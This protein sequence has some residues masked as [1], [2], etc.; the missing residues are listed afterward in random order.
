MAKLSKKL[1]LMAAVSAPIMLLAASGYSQDFDGVKIGFLT[2][3]SGG[4]S[5]LGGESTAE[6]VRMAIE[7]F[8]GEVLGEPIELLVGDQLNKPDVGLAIAR[9][10][11]ESDN[12]DVVVDVN[13][14]AVALAVNDIA[15]QENRIFM[16]GASSPD[17]V[18]E[19]CALTT[20][21]WN[22]DTEML[23]RSIA[24]PLVDQGFDNWFFI[25]ADYTFGHDLEQD[26]IELIEEAGGNVVGSVRHPTTA[27]DFS[28]FLLEAQA[29]GADTLALATFGT[30]TVNAIKQAREFGMDLKVVPYFLTLTDIQGI[31][32]ENLEN[33]YSATSFYWDRTDES[34]AWS[35]R[36]EERWSRP[37][38]FQ[39]AEHYSS[40]LHYLKAVE[41]A[42]TDEAGA[43]AEA[44]REMPIEDETG[45][46]AY[47]RED[48]RVMRDMYTFQV[49][50]PE[51]GESE[52]AVMEITGTL[53]K[54]DAAPP[55]EASACEL[56][57]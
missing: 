38:T 52:W 56:A 3:M 6:A 15:Q 47:I 34:R 17:I 48:G 24:V 57:Q 23:A 7:D 4:A 27:T 42:G 11:F 29:A 10:W 9:E 49:R 36:Y 31:G 14:S 8:G 21:Q 45:L 16:S 50:M 28:S 44:M 32:L 25:T 12:V 20:T 37:P 35:E 30:F 18:G 43:V 19:Q 1:R 5:A 39:N 55:L 51:D 53:D 33:T 54:E 26:S 13:S 46:M 40:V 22:A 2:D 41:A